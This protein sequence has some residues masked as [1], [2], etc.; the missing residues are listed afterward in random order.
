MFYLLLAKKHQQLLLKNAE[1]RPAREVR[2]TTTVVNSVPA[3]PVESAQLAVAEVHTAQAS[4]RP[5]KG[6][7]RKSQPS[8]MAREMRAYGKSDVHKGYGKKDVQARRDQSRPRPNPYKS[9]NDRSQQF[10]G[11]CHKCGRK[12]HFAKDCRTPPYMVNMYQELQQLH[13]QTHQT[14]NF[15]NSQPI[16]DLENYMTIYEQHSL[17]PDEAFLDN[18]STHTILTNPKFFHFKGNDELW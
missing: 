12:G 17:N 7:Y 8:H 18:V 6:S 15:E 1:S 9:K 13:T 5:P 10:Q 4:R 11:N 16:T 3:G 14:Y 2:S